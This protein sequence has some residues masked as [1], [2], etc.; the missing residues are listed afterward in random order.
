MIAIVLVRVFIAL[1]LAIRRH[2]LLRQSPSLG[3]PA[4]RDGLDDLQRGS[5]VGE[6]ALR[7]RIP[8][9]RLGARGE[10]P[11]ARLRIRRGARG[12]PVG[13][14]IGTSIGTFI[15]T[16]IG[17]TSERAHRAVARLER[18]L[19]RAHLRVRATSTRVRRREHRR[20]WRRAQ[21]AKRRV[22]LV[23]AL[24]RRARFPAV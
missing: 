18:E 15:G 16:F 13:T 23:R 7:V 24:E 4:L 1:R 9:V 20:I 6:G 22:R 17:T 12:A 14:A 19:E 11:R 2:H 3:R 5:K 8:R 21:P 10:H